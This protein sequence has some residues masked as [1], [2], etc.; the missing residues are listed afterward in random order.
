[1]KN[2]LPSEL[3]KQPRSLDACF[4]DKPH[5]RQRLLE[6]SDMIEALVAEGCSAHE[7]EAKWSGDVMEIL[8]EPSGAL[9][10]RDYRL[11]GH[12]YRT[13]AYPSWLSVA[14]DAA[15]ATRSVLRPLEHAA[16][17]GSN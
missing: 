10:V 2:E 11:D 4:A 9:E 17:G 6:I 15:D 16:H 12:L 14:P 5:L 8:V 1:M 7:A 3:P 13:R